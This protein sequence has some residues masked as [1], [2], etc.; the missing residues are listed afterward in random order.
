MGDRANICAKSHSPEIY[1]YTHWAGTELPETLRKALLR[2]KYRW[3][4]EQY[5]NRII[6]NEMTMGHERDN[7][8]FGISTFVVDG[9]KRIIVV[10]HTDKT[11]SLCDRT[12]SFAEYVANPRAWDRL[13]VEQPPTT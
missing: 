4:D 10:N 1:F 3:D 2:G 9:D 7:T 13:A 12:F 6:F 5:L 11:V 8:G